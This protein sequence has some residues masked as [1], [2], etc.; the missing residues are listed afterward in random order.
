MEEI[1]ALFDRDLALKLFAW[2]IVFALVFEAI[3][4]QGRLSKGND[5]ETKFNHKGNKS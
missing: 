5:P 2:G 1:Y 3:G 4:A